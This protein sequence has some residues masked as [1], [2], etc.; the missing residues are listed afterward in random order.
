MRNIALNLAMGIAALLCLSIIAG[1]TDKQTILYSFKGKGDGAGPESALVSDAAGN[2]Y[3]TTYHGG[4]SCDC[5]TAFELSPNS[6]G[7]WTKTILHIFTEGNDGA[8]PFGALVLDSNGNLFGETVVGG[9]ADSGTVFELSPNSTGGWTETILYAFKGAPDGREPSGGLVF[10]ASGNLYG[11]TF[12]GGTGNSVNCISIFGCG[13]AFELSPS[14]G[15]WIETVLYDFTA[16]TDGN[17]PSCAL[18]ID[19]SGNLY[20]TA[21]RGGNYGAGTVFQLSPSSDG[22]TFA[23]LYSFTDASGEGQ[24][25]EAGLLLDHVGNLYGTTVYSVGGNWCSFRTVTAKHRNDLA[26]DR[27]A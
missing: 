12:Y 2:L 15:G 7:G 16:S 6:G 1:A 4:S 10:D 21:S 19:N 25:P 13:T 26:R 22:W 23:A 3:G 17:W 14:A 27:A 20:G 11:T 18:I 8:W 24:D 5:G 9:P